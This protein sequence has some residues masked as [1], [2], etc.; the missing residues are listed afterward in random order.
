MDLEVIVRR[1]D[2]VRAH[3]NADR[4]D[5]ARVGGY[6]VVVGKGEWNAGRE[7]V[8][9]PEASVL[10]EWLIIKLGLEGRLAGKKKNR[11]KAVRLRGSLS[12]GLLLPIEDGQVLNDETGG[13]APA[14]AGQDYA[15][16]LGVVK[17]EPP[18]PVSM[19]GEC[20]PCPF[21]LPKIDVVDWKRD[22]EEI[23]DGREMI[24]TEKLHGTF[25]L[26]AWRREDA[27]DEPWVASKGLSAKGLAFKRGEAAKNVLYRQ[28]VD[29]IAPALCEAAR[30]ARRGP[31]PWAVAWMG[32][33]VGPKVQDLQYG[34]KA[35]EL[36]LFALWRK[37]TAE[38]PWTMLHPSEAHEAAAKAG[39]Q[40]VS[41]LPSFAIGPKV[42]AEEIR[43][44]QAEAE[45]PSRFSHVEQI[46]E[47][48]VVAHPSGAV[49]K[50]VS[51]AYLSRRGGTEYV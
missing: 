35:P 43:R 33:T 34:R 11:V 17:Y 37:E 24:V 36:A 14:E 47:G 20:A 51:E 26:A 45:G 40:T 15:A 39:V 9:L 23:A 13:S 50:I 22:P 5:L 30:K 16:L 32:E 21:P 41:L 27:P 19:S 10:P 31:P 1:I 18:V 3:P 6:E 46:R 7:A 44:V 25:T 2:E 29:P 38:A 28:V 4:L 49:R 8:F 42:E 48:L 12:Q